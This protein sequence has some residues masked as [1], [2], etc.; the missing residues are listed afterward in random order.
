M[1]VGCD[2]VV[3]SRIEKILKRR[4]VSFLE[5]ILTKNERDFF[6]GKYGI[7]AENPS[8]NSSENSEN[9]SENLDK[10][11]A[12]NSLKN[13]DENFK[14]SHKISLENSTKILSENLDKNSS[15]NPAFTNKSTKFNENLAQKAQNIA[16]LFAAK[17][18][19]SKALGCGICADFGFLD[20]EI[21]KDKNNAPKIKF[22]QKTQKK[23][24]IKSSSVSISHDGGFAIAVVVL[25]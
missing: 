20:A 14:N 19:I 3:I 10:N 9:S 6:Y 16:A 21:Y 13:L 8:T 2:I 4:G 18:A 25:G 17:E 15:K 12:E 11:L 1:R 24:A 7:L 23:F 5:M 22:N